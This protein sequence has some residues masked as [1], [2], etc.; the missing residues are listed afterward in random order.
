MLRRATQQD[1]APIYRVHMASIRALAARSYTAAQID[2]W[3]SGRSPQSY[4]APIQ[5]QVV[6]VAEVQGEIAG[7]AQLAPEQSLVV[8]VYVSPVHVRRGIGLR[9][10]R[11]LEEHALS[12]GTEE[13]QLQASLNSVAFYAH[14]GYSAGELKHH[15]VAGGVRLPC[16]AMSRTLR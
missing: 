14:A 4:H 2:A 7:F 6:V 16:T 11:A 9:L 12:L 1:A 13:L 15:V 3:C 8:A 10:L 5:E